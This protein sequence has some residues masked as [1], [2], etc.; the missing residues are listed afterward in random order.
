MYTDQDHLMMGRALQQAQRGLFAAPPNPSVGCVIVRGDQVLGEGHTQPVGHSHAEIMALKSCQ[1]KG[2]S[3]AGATVYVTLE[4]CSHFGKTPPCIHALIEAKVGKVIA[5]MEDPN[6][7]VSGK[8]FQAL[9]DAGIEVRCGLRQSE[10]QDIALGFLTR[11]RRGTPW[12]RL[13]V[14]GSIDAFSALP[15]G[16]SQ[17]ITSQ[18]A[19]DDG[20]RWRARASAIL[21][22]I[23]TVKADNPHMTVRAVNSPRQPQRILVDSLLEVDPKAHLLEGGAVIYAANAPLEKIAALR[24]QG[25]EVVLLPNASGKV[26]L[27]AMM[28]DLGARGINE[29]HVEAGSKLNGSLINEGCVDELLIY[30]APMLLGAG[31]GLFDLPALKQLQDAAVWEIIETTLIKPDVRIRLQRA[32]SL[33]SAPLASIGTKT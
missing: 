26:D 30:L 23:G 19:R 27:K 4:P 22:G 7:L 24:A 13:K 25:S 28:H 31:A 8:G 6:P 21:T 12:V 9:R 5:A 32:G 16:Q 29:L 33:V 17:W 3:A 11:M 20:H 1:D 14:A 18:P 2:E 15:N 10:A